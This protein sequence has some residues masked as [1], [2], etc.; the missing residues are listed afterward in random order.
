[1]QIKIKQILFL[2]YQPYN[3][4]NSAKYYHTTVN[5][6]KLIQ[7]NICITFLI[8][9]LFFMTI[10]IFI[11][12]TFKERKPELKFNNTFVMTVF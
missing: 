4:I 9:I 7:K 8:N 1:M 3:T 11:K 10:Y 6:G 2:T 12:T 5:T